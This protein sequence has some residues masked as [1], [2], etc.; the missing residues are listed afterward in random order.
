MVSLGHNELM[1]GSNFS[2]R[3]YSNEK[4][5][6]LRWWEKKEQWYLAKIKYYLRHDNKANENMMYVSNTVLR[7]PHKWCRVKD[8]NFCGLRSMEIAYAC[9]IV[10]SIYWRLVSSVTIDLGVIQRQGSTKFGSCHICHPFFVL[11][12]NDSNWKSI[13]IIKFIYWQLAPWYIHGVA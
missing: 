8:N 1:V 11:S 2:A 5:S 9:Y 7:K 3:C 10:Y 6:R 12:L 4:G 13:C